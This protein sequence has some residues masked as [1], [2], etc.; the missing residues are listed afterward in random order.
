MWIGC[1]TT[2]TASSFAVNPIPHSLIV[3]AILCTEWPYCSVF[4]G[5]FDLAWYHLP[6]WEVG[7]L[8][9]NRGQRFGHQNWPRSLRC[10]CKHDV[11]LQNLQGYQRDQ[12]WQAEGNMKGTVVSNFFYKR[13]ASDYYGRLEFLALEGLINWLF[14][15]VYKEIPYGCGVIVMN[16]YVGL[17]LP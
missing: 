8:W 10:W 9:P 17:C 6:N 11:H 13:R 2:F 14:W 12:C 15:G 16:G 5:C 1:W 3:E 4:L 7:G